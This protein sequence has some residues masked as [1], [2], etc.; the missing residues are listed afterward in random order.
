MTQPKWAEGLCDACAEDVGPCEGLPCINAK[1]PLTVMGERFFHNAVD[2]GF[3]HVDSP[4]D[5]LVCLA[6]VTS[7]VGEAVDA[8]R[9][10]DV[11]EHVPEIS[12][13]AEEL[14]DIII[15][16]LQM[17]VEHGVDMDDAVARKHSFNVGRPYMHGG[18]LY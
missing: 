2:H 5:P 7:E 17:A 18:K 8:F 12:N 9:K 14:A 1:G 15:R 10:P 6:L 3:C 16:T 13:Y 11:S 4:R